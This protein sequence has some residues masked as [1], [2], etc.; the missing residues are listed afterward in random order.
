MEGHLDY[1]IAAYA[2]SFAL[3]IG[4]RIWLSMKRKALAERKRALEQAGA[5]IESSHSSQA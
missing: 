2:I 3:L 5:H 4:Y 1:L